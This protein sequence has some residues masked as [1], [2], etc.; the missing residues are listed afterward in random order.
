MEKKIYNIPQTEVVAMQG[1]CNVMRTS[2]DP[3]PDPA[4]RR[5]T[6]VF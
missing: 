3:L 6:Q 1:L 2:I 5:R 4:P